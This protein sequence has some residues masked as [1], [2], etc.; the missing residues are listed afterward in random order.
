MENGGN[1]S[2]VESTFLPLYPSHDESLR[3]YRRNIFFTFIKAM[4]KGP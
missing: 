1:A 3:K 4:L 2:A